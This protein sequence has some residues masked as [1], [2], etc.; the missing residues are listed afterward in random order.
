MMAAAR[1][2]GQRLQDVGDGVGIYLVED[3]GS[4]VGFEFAGDDGSGLSGRFIENVGQF[5]QIQQG[6]Q[7]P[8]LGARRSGHQDALIGC[9]HPAEHDCG[10]SHPVTAQRIQHRL[11]Q[12]VGIRGG[13]T[14]RAVGWRL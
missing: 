7:Q 3:I 12:G 5:V 1:S 4:A 10:G 2:S 6:D 14:A 13:G 11:S 8:A 9:Q